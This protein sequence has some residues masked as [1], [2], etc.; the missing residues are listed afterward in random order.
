[1]FVGYRFEPRPKTCG[2]AFVILLATASAP[3]LAADAA[4]AAVTSDAEGHSVIA[5]PASFF[6]SM[7]LDTAYDMVLRVPGFVFDDGSNVRG[8]AGAAGN[9]LIDGERPT[10]KTDDLVS[11]LKRVPASAVERIDLIRGG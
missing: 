4:A 7:G 6:A 8:F 1:M 11:I 2:V 10:S 9:V 3:A 5:Y